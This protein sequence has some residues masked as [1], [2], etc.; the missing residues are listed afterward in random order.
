MQG[1]T[2]KN[3]NINEIVQELRKH[4]DQKYH[5]KIQVLFKEVIKLLDNFYEKRDKKIIE[6]LEKRPLS[7]PQIKKKLFGDN[8][9]IS[10]S[11]IKRDY[12]NEMLKN[13]EIANLNKRKENK[14]YKW[15]L[16]TGYDEEWD[17]K[18]NQY[19]LRTKKSPEFYK[20]LFGVAKKC[21]DNPKI[22][23]LVNK[24]AVTFQAF[25]I[26]SHTSYE[27]TIDE[28][29]IKKDLKKKGIRATK[30]NKKKRREEIEQ[31]LLNF[32]SRNVKIGIKP[33]KI[34]MIK[35]EGKDYFIL[36]GHHIPLENLAKFVQ[37]IRNHMSPK[38]YYFT[39]RD[40]VNRENVQRLM[41]KMADLFF[42]IEKESHVKV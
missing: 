5:D 41:G 13:R 33:E 34:N 16:K 27:W 11:L 39:H 30:E 23:E 9:G 6:Y 40:K 24:I 29:E 28:R 25:E 38:M 10:K 7:I 1:E 15:L 26:S 19:Y 17:S 32:A 31:D 14:D 18:T 12:I 21:L 2:P 8:L 35:I 36:E 4:V 3:I 20:K 22:K 42:A 37:I